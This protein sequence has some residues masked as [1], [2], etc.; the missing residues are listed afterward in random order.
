ME[1]AVCFSVTE[2][3]RRALEFVLRV[4]WL[5]QGETHCARKSLVQAQIFACLGCSAPCWWPAGH[6]K[7]HKHACMA[8]VFTHVYISV[9]ANMHV[10]LCAQCVPHSV[11]G[12]WGSG[13]NSDPGS[14]RPEESLCAEREDNERAFRMGVSVE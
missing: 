6:G 10:F 11:S 2:G 12:M 5:A 4:F 7:C 3:D 9:C 13:K 14:S 1:A 8:H